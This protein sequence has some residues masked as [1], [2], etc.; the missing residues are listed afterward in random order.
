MDSKGKSILQKLP[1]LLTS[2]PTK[3]QIERLNRKAKVIDK[4]HKIIRRGNV[5]QKTST[6]LGNIEINLFKCSSGIFQPKCIDSFRNVS[7]F[8][9]C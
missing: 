3:K 7:G 8:L 2:G 6:R 5:L 4:K 1:V 9:N